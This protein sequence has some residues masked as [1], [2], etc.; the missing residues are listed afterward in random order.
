MLGSNFFLVEIEFYCE[1]HFGTHFD[2][3]TKNEVNK[4]RK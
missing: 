1:K 3:V 4:K 2:H